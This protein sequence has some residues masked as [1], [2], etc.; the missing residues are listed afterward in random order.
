MNT[1]R[2]S[3]ALV[4]CILT[5][6]VATERHSHASVVIHDNR[7]GTFQWTPTVYLGDGNPI[8]GNFLDIRQ[9]PEQSGEQK[10]GTLQ[11]WFSYGFTGS[12][13]GIW[14]MQGEQG[15]EIADAESGKDVYWNG[16]NHWTVPMREYEWGQSVQSH[17]NWASYAVYYYSLPF[18]FG[19][20]G[21]LP[22]ID[23]LTYFGVRIKNVDNTYTYGW[24]LFEDW[25]K[26]LM[27]AYE[28]TPNTPIQIPIPAPNALGLMLAGTT[29][30]LRRKR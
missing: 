5:L 4:I 16:S 14:L 23:D 30:T 26:P 22:W 25:S 6:L 2:S 20:T 18:S 10:A 12:S 21:G 19:M 3:T 24:V 11:Q 15:T 1:N 17:D 27:W 7:D 9:S 28:T 29:L 8:Y 13:P